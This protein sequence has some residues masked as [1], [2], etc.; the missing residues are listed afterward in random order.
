MV[1]FNLDNNSLDAVKE[2]INSMGKLGDINSEWAAEGS[3]TPSPIQSINEMKIVDSQKDKKMEEEVEEKQINKVLDESEKEERR[4]KEE[5]KS[6]EDYNM[7][8]DKE[9]DND[10][11]SE[12]NEKSEEVNN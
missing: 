10:N 4:I 1:S 2:E 6:D 9:S 12:E 8:E 3:L 11:E 7:G 5:N